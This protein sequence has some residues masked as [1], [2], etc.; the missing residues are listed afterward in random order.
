MALLVL[1]V[2]FVSHAQGFFSGSETP[3]TRAH[4]AYLTGDFKTM[5]VNLRQALEENPTDSLVKENALSLLGKAYEVADKGQFQVDWRLPD[6]ITMLK[7]GAKRTFK[8]DVTYR[9]TVYGST[10]HL[11]SITQLQVIQFPDQVILDKQ[12]GI[13]NWDDT[14][15]IPP[16]GHDFSIETNKSRQP[17]A[18]G[19]Y[20][21]N[22][23][24][25]DGTQTKGWF[26]LDDD[27]NASTSPRVMTPSMDQVFTT[28]NPTFF[29]QN[30][31]TPEYKPFERR[32]FWVGISRFEPPHY[33]WN[34]VW[35][36][37]EGPSKREQITIDSHGEGGSVSKLEK[38][39]Y[40]FY[41]NYHERRNFGDLIITRDSTTSR[42]F[43]ISQ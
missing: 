28:G 1:S 16:T 9:F 37:Y 4:Q 35:G 27:I 7:I 32:S 3:L 41:I 17:V 33:D 30:F 22:I 6:E 26:I 14:N 40:V 43:K 20:L 29:W 11:K 19:L 2:P 39:S 8:D 36:Y 24:L 42:N 23:T 13:G 10:A 21:L 31:I 38:G 18:G 15:T 34:E 12:A 25:S 5:A